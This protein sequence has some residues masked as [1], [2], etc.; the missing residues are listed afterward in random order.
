VKNKLTISILALIIGFLFIG[1]KE[2]NSQKQNLENKNVSEEKVQ[3][4]QEGKTTNVLC[5]KNE[6]PFQ[7]NPS[8]KDI[9]ELTLII[10][11]KKINGTYNWLPAEKDQR[12]GSLTGTIKDKVIDAQY[13]FTQEGNENTVLLKI[14]IY[15]DKAV[16]KG[17]KFE[18]GLNA[19]IKKIDCD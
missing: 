18:L 6:F 19:T 14:N 7:D 9:E 16:I 8:M 13:T 11:G 4:I 3:K 5:F 2:S 10:E 17:G 15:A 12:K 1:C